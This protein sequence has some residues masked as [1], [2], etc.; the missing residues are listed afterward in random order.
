MFS[1]RRR[2]VFEEYYNNE[3][4]PFKIEI[5][6]IDKKQH[7]H[8]SFWKGVLLTLALFALIAIFISSLFLL[9]WKRPGLYLEDCIHRSCASGFN[10][11]CINSTC[12]CPSF[13]FYYT[14][15]CIQKKPYGEYC[16][17]SQEQCKEGLICFNGKCS[18]N[19]TQFWNGKKCFSKGSHAENCDFNKCLDSLFLICD[20]TSRLCLCDST[21]F[22]SDNAC[23][24]KRLYNEICGSIPTSCRGDLRLICLNGFCKMPF[25]FIV[26]NFYS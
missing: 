12:Q 24:K 25:Y 2:I 10:L 9:R 19:V 15:K 17:N 21:R 16:H 6:K 1:K 23:Y 22:W 20:P 13:D 18:C 4:V 26:D 3:I 8:A 5:Y 7:N 14:D 11:K